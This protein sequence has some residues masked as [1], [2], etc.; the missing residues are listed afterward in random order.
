MHIGRLSRPPA[1]RRVRAGRRP[2]R[3][4]HARRPSL[5]DG[6]AD[7]RQRALVDDLQRPARR[8][9]RRYDRLEHDR[10][11]VPERPAQLPALR[12]AAAD[13]AGGSETVHDHGVAGDGSRRPVHVPR[14]RHAL[15]RRLPEPRR[16]GLERNSTRTTARRAF[17]NGTVAIQSYEPFRADMQTRFKID[18]GRIV[19]DAINLQSTGASTSVTGYVDLSRW[20]EML[21]HV[22]SRI[23]F[24]T[25]KSIFFRSM[26]FTT[27]GHGDFTGTFHIFKGGREL[28]GTFTS[29]EAAVERLAVPGREGIPAL[30]SEPLRGVERHDR[31]LRRPGRLSLRPGAARRARAS[32]AVHLGHHLC[33]RRSGP[34]DGLS[35]PA[36]HPAV[37]T[38]IGAE[39]PRMAAWPLCRQTRV[40]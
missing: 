22:R 20:P 9:R 36:G 25:Q 16:H 12:R 39:P 8:P 29:P 15:E 11:G 18:G 34:A 40:R 26:N 7:S 2:H 28:R 14:P 37:R 17:S 38:G 21:Y 4:A 27:G 1:D 3:R 31:P 10:R 23:D 32:D 24:Q 30:D 19:L 5:P 6:K 35:R 33:G 13:E